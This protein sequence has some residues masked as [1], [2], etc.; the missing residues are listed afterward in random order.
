VWASELET[1]EAH[2]THTLSNL[3]YHHF[4]YQQHRLP[5]QVHI[6]FFGTSAFSFGQFVELQSGDEMRVA[7]DGFGR[8]LRNFLILDP[9]QEKPVDIRTIY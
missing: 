9:Q 8:P 1:G 6:H 2:I 4:K 5:G 3:E 7:F